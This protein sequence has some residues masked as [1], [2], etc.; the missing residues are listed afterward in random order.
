MSYSPK[1]FEKIKAQYEEAQLR[2]REEQERNIRQ[3]RE[4]IPG[5]SEIDDRLAATGVRIMDAIKNNRPGGIDA[6]RAEN[7]ELVRKRSALLRAHG[8]PEDYCD[9]HYTCMRCHDSGF[10]NGRRCICMKRALF[11]A[12]AELSGLGALLKKQ[13]FDNFST[14][15]YPDK[16]EAARLVHF[17]RKYA[18]QGVKQGE[19]LMLMGA[20]GLGKTHLSTSIARLAMEQGQ[21]VV[22]ESASNLFADFQYERFEKSRFDHS[23]DSAQKYFEADLLIVDDLGS[24]FSN[25]FTVAT[26]Y[27]LLNTRLNHQK[28]TLFNT[29]LSAK[30]LTARY[31]RRITSRILGEFTVFTLEGQDIRMQKLGLL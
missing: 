27:N 23:Y 28:A 22:Y 9:P 16:E 8:Y 10:E 21:S 14:E 13:S 30:E 17:C 20:T 3:V 4:K 5:M 19:N 12:Q 2:V 29:N 18:E 24:E 15:Y 25:Q 1:V 11:E 6:V 26:L 31:D 7:E